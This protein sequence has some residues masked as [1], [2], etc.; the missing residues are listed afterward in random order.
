MSA[1]HKQ[2]DAVDIAKNWLIQFAPF[3]ASCLFRRKLEEVTQV[4]TACI[5][6]HGQIKY[7]P[8]WFASLTIME[9]AFVLAHECMHFMLMH[10]ARIGNRDPAL[11][12]RAC[13]GVI[14]E[15]LIACNVGT[16]PEG[17]VRWPNA[18]N[19]TA[20]EVYDE[21]V[22]AG[23]TGEC[24][25]PPKGG[26]G[27]PCDDGDGEGGSSPSESDGDDK[28]DD[29][30]DSSGAGKE[31]TDD[32]GDDAGSS[33]GTEPDKQDTD[34]PQAGGT[35]AGGDMDL[36][37]APLTAEEKSEM[38]AEVRVEMHEAVESA[39]RMGNM[40]AVLD[41]F[42]SKLMEVK[43]PWHAKLLRFMTQPSDDDFSWAKLDRRYVSQDLYLPW[44]DGNSLGEVAII[45]DV[46]GSIGSRMKNHF[47]SHLNRIL[48]T[49]QPSKVIAIPCHSDVVVDDIVE[50]TPDE[51]PVTLDCRRSGGT[52]M[53]EG[54]KY[55]YKNYPDVE[56]VVVLTDGYTPWGKD[57][58]DTP[59]LWAITTDI[60][61]P[62][63][64]TVQIEITD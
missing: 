1:Q 20:E 22:E 54:L 8:Q 16:M 49:C 43:T 30:G 11:W 46:S 41:K 31:P 15:M 29:D 26:Q 61:A 25:E 5:N 63:G 32:D 10:I 12:N 18:E 37:D 13:D 3:Y 19:M 47:A 52:C 36:S 40:P 9:V 42:T 50:F 62:W 48:D 51:Y 28:D 56:L 60:V 6:V 39:K 2:V 24:P 27:K 35:W 45:W 17:G 23:E 59:T 34:Q 57:V 53:P 7:N 14:N 44:F 58:Y 38:E 21:M 4:P 33:S 64:E 55:V